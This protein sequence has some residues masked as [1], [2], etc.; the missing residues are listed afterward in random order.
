MTITTGAIGALPAPVNNPYSFANEQ[1]FASSLGISP[2]TM[3]RD[4]TTI[5]GAV[6]A[7]ATGLYT[8]N[9]QTGVATLL[10]TLPNKV[11]GLVETYDG[12]VLC[13][14]GNGGT[15]YVYKST[16]WSTN[17]ATAT[18]GSPVLT[19]PGG[20]P[21]PDYSANRWSM[22]TNGVMVISEQGGQSPTKPTATGD[23]AADNATAIANNAATAHRAYVTVNN[24]STW[25]L[26]HDQLTQSPL[27]EPRLIQGTHQHSWM[28]DQEWDRMWGNY[29][30][31][32]GTGPALYGSGN[33]QLIYS[34]DWRNVLTGGT[35]TWNTLPLL[36]EY[37]STVS[38]E[39][40][41]FVGMLITSK[42]IIMGPDSVPFMQTIIPR[43]GY[44]TIGPIRRGAMLPITTGSNIIGKDI[45][46]AGPGFPAFSSFSINNTIAGDTNNPSY[47]Y[48]P[49]LY[50]TADEGL[51]WFEIWRDPVKTRRTSD[52]VAAFGPTV[53]NKMV[54]ATLDT[55]NGASANG[56]IITWDLV[57]NS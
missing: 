53:N 49:H 19:L 35:A 22:G 15:G 32:T 46:W 24:G 16:G 56:Y 12:E 13:V 41:Q 37:P 43:T 8:I 28:Y 42:A 23:N 26:L 55:G 20:I 6:R 54:A 17:K 33:L 50:A 9:D 39:A 2:I 34:D 48:L 51:N 36:T 45:A 38:A 57:K 25:T 14:C 1:R 5:Y 47:A 40:Q 52:K 4:R 7:G 29:G 44:R 11:Y 10:N 27:L 18:W 30:D 21:F 3:S 31:G